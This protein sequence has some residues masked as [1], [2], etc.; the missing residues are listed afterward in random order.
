[1][2][3]TL[4]SQGWEIR[5]EGMCLG[6]GSTV[7]LSDINALFPADR[8]SVI[9]GG[10][11]CGKSTLLRHVAG[12]LPPLAGKT[13]IGG[14]DL[15]TLPPKEFR[16]LRRRMGVM[17][18]DGA[19]LGA[20]TLAQNVALP[21]VEH[22]RLS[23]EAIHA[24]ALRCL[25]LVGL[26]DFGAYFPAQLSGG[27]RKRAGLA[28]ALITEPR[29]LLCDEPASGLDPVNAA[30]MDHLLLDMKA[31]HPG[32]SLVVVS[33]DLASLARIADD[34]LVL[35]EGGA[36]FQGN[37][38]DLCAVEDAYLHSFLHRKRPEDAFRQAHGAGSPD[39]DVRAA[40][41]AWLDK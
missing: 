32:M 25:T 15:F 12:L 37:Y 35:H 2:E 6:Y 10:S 20:L 29:I 27:M 18:Q 3:N 34:I 19:L 40:L 31:Q 11:G 28:R 7:V 41:L 1:M 30:R 36:I 22:T 16:R 23:P 13:L 38:T 39:P 26:Q 21:L 4:A 9:L 24:E 17:F 5:L 33:H 8:I 14:Q